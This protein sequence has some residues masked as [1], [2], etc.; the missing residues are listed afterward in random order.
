[1]LFFA[2]LSGCFLV[3]QIPKDIG[4]DTSVPGDVSVL[5]SETHCSYFC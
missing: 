4:A 3:A 5:V 2:V 1:M